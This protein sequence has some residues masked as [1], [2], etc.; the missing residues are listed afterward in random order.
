VYVVKG[1][2]WYAFVVGSVPGLE[3][4]KCNPVHRRQNLEASI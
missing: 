4:A 3:K 1:A 2:F